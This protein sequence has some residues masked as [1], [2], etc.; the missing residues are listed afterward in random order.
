MKP[1]FKK[2]FTMKKLNQLLQP[3]AGI[4]GAL[5]IM[6]PLQ[7][8]ATELNDVSYSSLTGGEVQIRLKLDEV[9]ARPTSFITNNPAKIVV[10]IPNTSSIMS[11]RAKPV[12]SGAVRSITAIE[13]GSTTRVIIDLLKSTGYSID[14][15][16]TDVLVTIGGDT[17]T[18]TNTVAESEISYDEP[19]S[20]IS[21]PIANLS[22]KDLKGLDFRRGGDGEGQVIVT[23]SDPSTVVDLERKGGKIVARF[24]NTTL[25]SNLKQISDVLDFATPVSEMKSYTK[26]NDTYVEI[27]ARGKYD[28]FS[29]QT[30]NKYTI[31]FREL[32]KEEEEKLKKKESIE[33]RGDKL[34]LNF[35]DIEV[36]AVLQLLA[37]FTGIN[38]VVSDSVDGNITLRLNDVP[39]DHALDIILKTNGLSKRQKDNVMLIAPTEEITGQE[40]TEFQAK[41]DIEDLAPLIIEFIKVKYASAKDMAELLKSSAS[42]SISVSSELDGV[43]RSS[44][45]QNSILSDR[46][47][48]TVDERTNT[49]LIRDTEANLEQIL[50]IIEKLDVPVRQVLVEA[51]IVLANQDFSR[52]LGFRMGLNRSNNIKGSEL[53]IG[54]AQPGHLNAS[55]V[56]VGPFLAGLDGTPFNGIIVGDNGNNNLLVNLPAASAAVNG[57]GINFVLGKIGSYLLNLELTALQQ[58]GS[59]EVVSSPRLVTADSKKAIIKQGKAIPYL[60]SAGG[61]GSTKINF[62]DAL[63]KLEVTP[64]IT[65]DDRISMELIITKDNPDFTRQINGVPPIDKRRIETNVLVR[66][67]ETVVLGGVFESEKTSSIAKVPF[68]G[69]IPFIGRLF[70]NDLNK[71]SQVE[72]LIFITPKILK[73]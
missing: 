40:I 46:G 1:N 58:E 44:T 39:W 61:L 70:K 23:L 4:C 38:M 27:K 62:K 31:E 26:G 11:K 50:A 68:F 5:L 43:T 2:S 71:E 73:E 47:Q 30:N 72:L 7:L 22:S 9:V 54:G 36:R 19:V 49:L 8:L 57:G 69:D 56:N 53:L 3:R 42:N 12:G 67:G 64:H 24:E 6:T 10:D 66:N 14:V 25:P 13:S 18:N 41:K 28:Y 45:A 59:G 16:G 65:P 33:Y 15:Q 48:I 37:D 55:E 35:Q 34:S 20:N 29:Y 21:T 52:E 32:T 17:S 63:L 60:S 51:R